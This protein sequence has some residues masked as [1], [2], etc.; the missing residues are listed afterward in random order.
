MDELVHYHSA[1]SSYGGS[2][3]AVDAIVEAISATEDELLLPQLF[4]EL[5]LEANR[6]EWLFD[7]DYSAVALQAA[8]Q[9]VRCPA[10]RKAMLVFALG[11]ARWCASCATAGAEG[12]A[13][14]VHV[15]ELQALVDDSV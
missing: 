9:Q 5:E 1:V 8:S 15:G 2:T 14:S 12:L 6:I 11:R 7:S 10:L 3:A 4:S 13:R